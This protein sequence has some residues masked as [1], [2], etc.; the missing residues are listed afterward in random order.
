LIHRLLTFI[1]SSIEEER[2]RSGARDV[3]FAVT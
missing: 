1:L 2:K 3:S